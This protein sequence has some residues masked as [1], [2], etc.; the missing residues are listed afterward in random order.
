MPIQKI[1][2]GFILHPGQK[3]EFE[4]SSSEEVIDDPAYVFDQYLMRRAR[5]LKGFGDDFSAKFGIFQQSTKF[6]LNSTIWELKPTSEV[7]FIKNSNRNSELA[8]PILAKIKNKEL[9][10][11]DYRLEFGHFEALKAAFLVDPN[12][13]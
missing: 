3:N 13:L 12:C 7:A 6:N 11:S 10:L 5:H 8:L 4:K 2:R 1:R 9:V